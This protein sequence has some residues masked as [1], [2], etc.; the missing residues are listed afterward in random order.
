MPRLAYNKKICVAIEEFE[1]TTIYFYNC[2]TFEGSPADATY[3]SWPLDNDY[4]DRETIAE[5]MFEEFYPQELFYFLPDGTKKSCYLCFQVEASDK[6]AEAIT[7]YTVTAQGN[8]T[9]V[10]LEMHKDAEE[11]PNLVLLQ[12]FESWFAEKA[13]HKLVQENL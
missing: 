8:P 13:I 4:R 5:E 7:I 2:K 9:S 3:M 10:R 1:D 11:V 6:E 12:Q